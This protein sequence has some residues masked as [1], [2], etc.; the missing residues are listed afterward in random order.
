M[1]GHKN[2]K[3][4]QILALVGA[5]LLAAIFPAALVV[6]LMVPGFRALLAS[7][8]GDLAHEQPGTWI[9][10]AAL[11]PTVAFLAAHPAP[12][13]DLLRDLVVWRHGY[14]YRPMFWGSPLVMRENAYLGFDWAVGHLDAVMMGAGLGTWSWLPVTSLLAIG[15]GASI[16][17]VMLAQTPR[18]DAPMVLL[19]VILCGF[20]WATPEF[21]DRVR[22]GRPEA[23]ASLW[24]IC[25]LA[26]SRRRGLLLWGLL[27]VPVLASYWLACVYVPAVMLAARPLREK[28]A[29]GAALL[30]F[31]VCFWWWAMDGRAIQ[32]WHHV[33]SGVAA[34]IDSVGENAPF[35]VIMLGLGGL[36]LVVASSAAV[37][38]DDLRPRPTLRSPQDLWR[39]AADALRSPSFLL[40]A[41]LA[42]FLLPNMVRYVDVVAPIMAAAVARRA[43]RAMPKDLYGPVL[44]GACALAIASV[45]L[46]AIAA[47]APKPL[48]DL[49]LPQANP[50]DRVLTVFSQD[51]Y[52]AL[53]LNPQVSVAPAFELGFSRRDVQQA[54]LDLMRGRV[55]CAWL[56]AN[57]VAWVI[58][59]PSAWNPVE[60]AQCLDLVR[61]TPA[62]ATIWRVRTGV[63]DN[64]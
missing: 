52:A 38:A 53:Y 50:G 18:R 56:I 54:S 55:D 4:R 3:N 45:A 6:A 44:A 10:L 34:R 40:L 5:G 49:R 39:F 23:F 64:E 2:N 46:A 28:A 32:W 33:A 17:L 35:G 30:L 19:I 48:P 9:A 43:S 63:R 31:A 42:W 20:V 13:D 26:I 21:V 47:A 29:A 57:E 59:P 36:M 11:A 14:D 25:A 22:S 51:T 24:A 16:P 61:S 41:V 8:I 37:A 27:G 62:G 7:S 58:S 1:S 15:F 12:P 60:R